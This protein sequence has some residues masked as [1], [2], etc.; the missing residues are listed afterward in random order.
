MDRLIRAVEEYRRIVG[1]ISE[2]DHWLTT[3]D[4]ELAK[5]DEAL[6]KALAESKR[7]DSSIPPEKEPT[8]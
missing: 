7:Y 2:V 6:D 1:K 3:P 5:A 8:P 4:C